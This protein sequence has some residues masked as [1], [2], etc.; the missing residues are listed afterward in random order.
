[1]HRIVLAGAVLKRGWIGGEPYVARS[2]AAG[3]AARGHEVVVWAQPRTGIALGAMG[4]S[5]LDWD[6]VTVARYAR[7]LR[8]TRPSVVLGFYDYDTSLAYAAHLLGVPYIFSAHIYWPVCPIASLYI[9]GSGPCSGHSFAKCVRHMSEQVPDSRLSVNL[10][11]LPG[12]L[13]MLVYSKFTSRHALMARA[14]AIVVPSRRMAEILSATGLTR[15]HVVPDAVA[16]E[17]T[18]PGV[19]IA[20]PRRIL[21]PSAT[22]G[23]RK[24]LQQFLAAAALLKVEH[25][26]AKFVATNFAGDDLVDGT[27]FLSRPQFLSLLQGSFAVVAPAVWDEPFGLVITEAMAAGR[28]VVAYDSG[29]AGEI[30]VQGETGVIVPRGQTQALAAAISRLLSDEPLAERMGVAGRRRAE[31]FYSVSRMVD[32]YLGVVDEVLGRR[33][34]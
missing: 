15:V 21:L 9:D 11:R 13:G 18:Q 32:G 25:P 28:P 5:P 1:M 20:T 10:R 7:M 12:P 4:V 33:K 19:S 30:I 23:E 29:A 3:L 6:V 14:E 31:T 8:A 22:G 16:M 34:R 2:L 24:G 27:P 17:E 26:E